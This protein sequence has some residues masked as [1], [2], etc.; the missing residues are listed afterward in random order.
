MRVIRPKIL[1]TLKVQ[2]MM[3]G[4]F[5]VLNDIKNAPN[6]LIIP[7]DSQEHGLSIIEKL[8]RCKVGEEFYTSSL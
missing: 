7:C 3:A 8:K 6:K 4:N 2:I 1:G 5:A